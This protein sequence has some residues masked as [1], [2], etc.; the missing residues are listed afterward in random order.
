MLRRMRKLFYILQPFFKAKNR[1][2]QDL[3]PASMVM[4]LILRERYNLSYRD[5]VSFLN[6]T[7]ILLFKLKKIPSKSTLNDSTSSGS[8]H[9]TENAGIHA[10]RHVVGTLRGFKWTLKE[11]ISGMGRCKKRPHI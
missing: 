9:H 5:T 10:I 1:G 3:D 8:Y 2:R 7:Q 11:Q 4:C 6:S